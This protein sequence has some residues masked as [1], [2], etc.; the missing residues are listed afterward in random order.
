MRLLLVAVLAVLA[1][2]PSGLEDRAAG[3]DTGSDDGAGAG[4]AGAPRECN[5]ANDCAP[6]GPKCCDCPTHAVPKTDPAYAAC[7]NVDCPTPQ[8]GSPMEAACVQGQCELVCSPVECGS[9]CADGF[10][11]DGNGCLTCACAA[12]PSKEC[13]VDTDCARVRNDCCGCTRGGTDTAVPV[14]QVAAHDA[15]LMCP[16]SPTCPDVDVCVADLA[17]RCVAGSCTLVAGALPSGACGRPDLPACPQGQ[18]CV[19]NANDQATMHGVG[20]CLPAP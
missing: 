18:V 7:S 17:A 8:C 10:A 16:Q 12:P 14:G 13:S 11:T 5:V 6:A 9:S 4:G 20:I 15:M 1:G 19:V 3:E 2:C